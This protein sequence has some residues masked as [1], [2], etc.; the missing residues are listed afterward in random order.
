[1]QGCALAAQLKREQKVA[2]VTSS[3][4]TLATLEYCLAMS[5]L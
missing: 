3:I 5:F 1:M 2:S 4:F